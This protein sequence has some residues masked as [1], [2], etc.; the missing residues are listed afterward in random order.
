MHRLLL[1]IFCLAGCSLAAATPPETRSESNRIQPPEETEFTNY[2]N[3]FAFIVG[4]SQYQ[5]FSKLEGPAYDAVAVAN[6]LAERYGFTVYLLTDNN[7][8]KV[9][10]KVQKKFVSH[11]TKETITNELRHFRQQIEKTSDSLL[12]FYYSGHGLRTVKGDQRLGFIVPANGDEK[13]PETVLAFAELAKE[14]ADYQ[15]HHTLFILDSCYSGAIF[16]P[17]S[18]VTFSLGK[19]KP[20]SKGGLERGLSQPVVQ[21]ITAGARDELVDDQTRISEQYKNMRN[22]D[23]DQLSK[24]SPFTAML[25]QALA[26]RIG[27]QQKRGNLPMGTIAASTLGYEMHQ[28][29]MDSLQLPGNYPLP[30]YRTLIGQGNA[31]LMP[32]RNLVLNPRIISPLYLPGERYQ[33]LRASGIMALLTEPQQTNKTLV[34]EALPH[35]NY[36]LSDTALVQEAALDVLIKLVNKNGQ[37]D[38][39]GK[40]IKPL[41]KILN[42][43]SGTD[44]PLR[45]KAATLLGKLHKLANEDAVVAMEHY[46]AQLLQKWEQQLKYSGQTKKEFPPEVTTQE[47]LA[48][49]EIEIET[50]AHLEKRRQA[51]RWLLTHGLDAISD[52]TTLGTVRNVNELDMAIKDEQKKVGKLEKG[53]AHTSYKFEGAQAELNKWLATF[54]KTLQE[55]GETRY[56]YYKQQAEYKVFKR[57]YRQLD[58]NL[59]MLMGHRGDF[60]KELEHLKKE[61]SQIEDDLKLYIQQKIAK[62]LELD[63]FTSG[64]KK[65]DK[66]LNK[67]IQFAERQTNQVCPMLDKAN[68][69]LLLSDYLLS[70]LPKELNQFLSDLLNFKFEFEIEKETWYYQSVLKILRDE[71]EMNRVSTQLK[72]RCEMWTDQGALKINWQKLYKNVLDWRE[73][74]V[75]IKGVRIAQKRLSPTVENVEEEIEALEKDIKAKEKDKQ[76]AE[77]VLQEGKVEQSRLQ[78]EVQNTGDK[79]QIVNEEIRLARSAVGEIKAQLKQKQTLLKTAK[80]RLKRLLRIR[81]YF[82]RERAC[83]QF[84]GAEFPK[85][86]TKTNLTG[87]KNLSG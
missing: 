21:A 41:I 37:L 15:A 27:I 40:I 36:A 78:V 30:R 79:L 57:R 7:Q 28:S 26:G 75:E 47:T 73:L 77:Q 20:N 68:S 24:H 18:Q 81:Q 86:S 85:P 87:V 3:R 56:Q 29:L 11:I 76:S 22:S 69:D 34:I 39:F 71:I 17:A 48:N 23:A 1:L 62:E 51:A 44:V 42:K 61:F 2:K 67:V 45:K 35:L 66:V 10:E 80:A 50:M 70:Q 54:V 59:N 63:K 9:T 19:G 60:E 33:A 25:T 65:I 5:H 14:I 58:V 32:V 12:V 74:L 84:R 38:D 82:C 64:W 72:Q 83:P 55:L 8:L 52:Y 53:I 31:L 43:P 13:K 46:I 6:I 16:E 49:H 4:I